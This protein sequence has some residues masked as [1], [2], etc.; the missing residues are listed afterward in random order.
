MKAMP[1]V[2]VSIAS[3]F[4]AAADAFVFHPRRSGDLSPLPTRTAFRHPRRSHGAQRATRGANLLTMKARAGRKSD[5]W[6]VTL[7]ER[8]VPL[9]E[10]G[11]VVTVKAAYAFNSLLPLKRAR[12]ATPNDIV[13][14][15]SKLQKEE[16]IRKERLK[17]AKETKASMQGTSVVVIRNP[18]RADPRGLA[19]FGSVSPKDVAEGLSELGFGVVPEDVKLSKEIV[20]YGTATA[21]V[22]VYETIMATVVVN[23]APDQA[24]ARMQAQAK[25]GKQQQTATVGDEEE[26]DEL[27]I[28]ET[29]TQ[30]AT[31]A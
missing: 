30:A 27:P 25:G 21:E 3:L 13:S 11:D 4:A 19:F 14:F 1:L 17:E 8:I 22:K 10:P 26:A 28:V 5:R 15:E 23:V 24:T 18:N 7:L 29:E 20:E 12:Q 16:A 31:A 9:G 6:Q 2:T